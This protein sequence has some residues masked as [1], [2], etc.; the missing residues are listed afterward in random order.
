MTR[1]FRWPRVPALSNPHPNGIET[2]HGIKD[3]PVDG[4]DKNAASHDIPKCRGS[5]DPK[6]QIKYRHVSTQH[7]AHGYQELVGDAMVESHNDKAR[8]GKPECKDFSGDLLC[9]R[10]LPYSKT[11]HKVGADTLEKGAQPGLSILFESHGNGK[12]NLVEIGEG[13]RTISQQKG[14]CEATNKVTTPRDDPI[15]K[16]GFGR[17]MTAKQ[18]GNK[19]E[20][21]SGKELPAGESD[22]DESSGKES[23]AQH[24]PSQAK[25]KLSSHCN[26]N[27]GHEGLES[28]DIEGES[29]LVLSGVV[30]GL[31]GLLGWISGAVRGG[32]VDHRGKAEEV[33][34]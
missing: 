6:E 21:I 34:P 23:T 15:P 17:D 9:A 18:T 10:G 26:V 8:N 4:P 24:T 32:H 12:V 31:K 33:P 14:P 5:K 27:T 30:D 3:I 11:D 16:H 1:M 28:K 29:S 7:H 19:N 2:L 22:G 13:V 20:G 25:E